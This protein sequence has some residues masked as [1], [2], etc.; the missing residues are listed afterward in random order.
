MIKAKLSDAKKYAALHPEFAMCFE[1]LSEIS[2]DFKSGEIKR[3]DVRFLCQEY[4]TKDAS[5]KKLEVHRKFIDIQFLVSGTEKI[6]FGDI[7]DFPVKVP[8][9]AEKDAEFLSGSP[10]DSATLKAGDFAVFFPEDAHKAG[11]KAENLAS[12]VKKV[13][14]KV[15][16]S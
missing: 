3:G 9:D 1:T 7:A 2:K 16:L 15:P 8:Y 6:F 14:V 12:D 11:C 13:V 10:I 5:E 4:L